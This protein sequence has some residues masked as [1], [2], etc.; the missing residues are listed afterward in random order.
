[1]LDTMGDP[2]RRRATYQDVLDAPPNRVAELIDG[3]LHTYP[4]PAPR[5]ALAASRLGMWFGSGF[6]G[7]GDGPLGWWILDEPELHFGEDVLVP[8]M[9][10]WRVERMPELPDA[11]YFELAPDWICEVLS[12]STAA[13]DR[14]DKL[15]RYAGQGVRHAWLVE[16]SVHTLEVFRLERERWSLVQTA[17][18]DDRLRAEPFEEAELDLGS[19]WRRPR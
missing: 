8:D 5:H 16:P 10:G 4:R 11:A 19:L 1:M 18:D 9:A 2:L 7:G 17:R 3:T 15:P 13:V 14:A 12:P 6:G